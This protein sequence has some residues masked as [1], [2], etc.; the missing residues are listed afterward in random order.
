M[1]KIPGLRSVGNASPEE[2][3]RVEQGVSETL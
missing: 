3:E 1:E 2:K